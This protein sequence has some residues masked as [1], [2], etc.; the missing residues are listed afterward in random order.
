M[1]FKKIEV[2]LFDK[3]IL[4]EPGLAIALEIGDI[5]I[6]PDGDREIKTHADLLQRG[7]NFFS[8]TLG[9][10]SIFYD[11]IPDHMIILKNFSPNAHGDS[12]WWTLVI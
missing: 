8:T 6:E 10:V 2:D 9:H 7:K 4:T 11:G 5:G 1:K 3:R 12:L